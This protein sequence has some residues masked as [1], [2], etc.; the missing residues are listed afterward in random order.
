MRGPCAYEESQS[1]RIGESKIDPV[2]HSQSNSHDR[3]CALQHAWPE[4]MRNSL[5]SLVLFALSNL[6]CVTG[7][8]S[9]AVMSSLRIEGEIASNSSLL[10]MLLP[11]G[12]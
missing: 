7:D 3:R 10:Y 12:I 2:S 4:D 8:M 6:V 5:F 11:C 9:P 1:S